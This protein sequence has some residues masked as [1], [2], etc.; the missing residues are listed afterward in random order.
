MTDFFISD[1]QWV[2][3]DGKNSQENHYTLWKR[4]TYMPFATWGYGS[5]LEG[6]GLMWVHPRKNI[7]E[8]SRGIF[9][10]SSFKDFFTT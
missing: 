7:F 10:Q 9:K 5:G 3:F 2:L 4:G 8:I 6:T 1:Q